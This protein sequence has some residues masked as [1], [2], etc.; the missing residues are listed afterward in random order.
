[1]LDFGGYKD[2]IKMQTQCHFRRKM[3]QKA[4][5]ANNILYCSEGECRSNFMKFG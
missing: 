1:M 4:W 5:N 2:G 3:A